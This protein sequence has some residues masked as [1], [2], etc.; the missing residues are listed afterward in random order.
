[1]AKIQQGDYLRAKPSVAD[2]SNALDVV[3]AFNNILNTTYDATQKAN[4]SKIANNAIELSNRALKLN[5]DI[6]LKYQADPTNPE[7]EREFKE[8]FELLAGEYNVGPFA[9]GQWNVAKDNIYNNFSSYNAKWQIKQQ[10]D[11][12]TNDLKNGYE[13]LNEQISMLG[14][15][16]ASYD[17]VRLVYENGINGLRNASVTSL[18]EI[19]TEN[20]LKDA[21]HDFMTSYIGSLAMENPLKAQALM[22]DDGVLNDIG[23]AQTIEKLN[24]YISTSLMNQH[25]KTAIAE[26]GNALRAM[27]SD[28]AND[29]INGRANINQLMRFNE[30]FKNMPEETKDMLNGI[31]GIRSENKYV[32]DRDSKSIKRSKD[33]SGETLSNL[34]L[35][36][37][38]KRVL[39]DELETGLQA[40]L[41]NPEDVI[42]AKDLK[43]KEQKEQAHNRQIATMQAIALM[44]GRIDSAV[45]TGAITKEERKHFM[46]KYIAPA[47]DFVEQNLEQLDE[48]NLFGKNLLGYDRIKQEFDVTD[49]KGRE[50][51]DVQQQ[52]LMAQSYYLDELH[53]V[54]QNTPGL[55][56][57]YDIE[58]KITSRENRRKIYQ[59]AAD[60]ALLKAKRWTSK[61]EIFFQK[62]FPAEYELPFKVFGQEKAIQINREVASAVYKDMY[63]SDGRTLD[64]KKLASDKAYEAIKREA[65]RGAKQAGDI[66]TKDKDKLFVSKIMTYED[67]EKALSDLDITPEEFEEFAYSQGYIDRKALYRALGEKSTNEVRNSYLNKQRLNALN[68]I[69]EAKSMKNKGK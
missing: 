18:G 45:A 64:I 49:L 23:N 63:E 11:N 8:S 62:E 35:T 47:S 56:S 48:G 37:V 2:T 53:Q 36:D 44:Q 61:P 30:R 27:G 39:A 67:F 32:Y 26:L 15:N 66:L 24:D 46:Q 6:N 58:T 55:N 50:L 21:N 60:N 52:K 20:F 57:I 42:N 14:K 17:E 38:Q 19:V 1:M 25:K 69:I 68:D 3:G 40:L 28:E 41:F 54:V 16:G 5:N 31:Y 10:Q 29:L 34:K 9:Q 65:L 7:R 12:A 43:S 13:A 59:T 4:A 51:Q 22:K 33:G